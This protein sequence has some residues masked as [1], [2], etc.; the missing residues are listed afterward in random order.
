M[1]YLNKFPS[2]AQVRDHIIP[3]LEDDE[4]NLNIRLKKFEPYMLEIL[5]SDEFDPSPAE[6][7]LAAFRVLDQEGKGFI[8]KDVMR[9]LL[10]TMVINFRE[11]EYNS[12]EDFAI[13]K[14]RQ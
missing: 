2:E 7:I 6:H 4:Q 12:F 3:L 11:K 5:M 14:S 13:D 9:N 10:T 8:A 1:R